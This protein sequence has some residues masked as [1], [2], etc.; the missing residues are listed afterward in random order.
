MKKVLLGTTA[1]VMSAGAAAA[2][3]SLSGYA[4]IGIKDAGGASSVEFHHDLDVTFKLSGETDNGLTFG[5]TID[6]DEIDH[7]TAAGDGGGIGG[8]SGSH[9]V[10]VSGSFGTITMGDTDGAFDAALTEVDSL[11]SI[12]DDHT[13]HSGFSGNDGLDGYND[14]QIL[15]YNYSFGEIV[16][17]VSAELDDTAGSDDVIGVG[18]R[19]SGDV[20]GGS[21]LAIGVG[22]QDNGVVDISGVSVRADMGGFEILANYT[23]HSTEGDYTAIGLVYSAGA[24]TFHANYGEKSG[25][26]DGAVTAPCGGAASCD[27]FGLAVN[28]DLGGGATAMVGYGDSSGSSTWSAGLGLSF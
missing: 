8:D 13:A 24:A 22:F 18:V 14:G 4:E 26:T 10:F 19:W 15:K 9:S 7:D 5:A 25:N 17:D 1:L 28:Y 23:D 27:G 11:T 3:V 16:F 12:A 21:G 2:D 20:G 6:L